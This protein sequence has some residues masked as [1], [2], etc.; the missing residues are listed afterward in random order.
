LRILFSSISYYMNSN[1]N[2]GIWTNNAIHQNLKNRSGKI[3]TS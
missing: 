1:E 3:H 2:K